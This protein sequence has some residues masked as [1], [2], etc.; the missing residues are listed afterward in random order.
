MLPRVISDVGS[1]L[2]GTPLPL[3]AGA[4][5][6]LGTN[7]IRV[8]AGAA[9]S[10]QAGAPP[11]LLVSY[12]TPFTGHARLVAGTFSGAAVPPA[13]WAWPPPRRRPRGSGCTRAAA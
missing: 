7:P 2:R 10:A 6:S 1:G 3:A 8:S 13:R 9:A 12:R 4:W 11:E 5:G